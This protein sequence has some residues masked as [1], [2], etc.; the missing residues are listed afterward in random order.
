[1]KKILIALTTLFLI[2]TGHAQGPAFCAGRNTVFKN[3]ENVSFYVFYT[4]AGIWVHAGTARFIV[5]QERLD[6]KPV[7]NGICQAL[8]P[9]L[10]AV[11][12]RLVSSNLAGGSLSQV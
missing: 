1:M 7:S 8:R 4:V 12:S 9:E 11:L 3:G 6:N 2:H 5:T 10:C